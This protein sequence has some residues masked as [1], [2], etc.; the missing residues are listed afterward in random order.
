[1]QQERTYYYTKSAHA[2]ECH[3]ELE[4][5]NGGSTATTEAM[6]HNGDVRIA[7]THFGINDDET[8]CPVC[9]GTQGC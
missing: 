5:R 7:P 9:D 8:Y 4:K 1:M 3:R 6:I 2:T